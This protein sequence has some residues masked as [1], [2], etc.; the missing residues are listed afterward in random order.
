MKVNRVSGWK[1]E[2][3]RYEAMTERGKKKREEM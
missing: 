1:P 3:H 2:L